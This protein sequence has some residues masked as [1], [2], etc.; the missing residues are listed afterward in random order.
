[1]KHFKIAFALALGAYP[2]YPTMAGVQ[3]TIL[4]KEC[5]RDRCVFYEGSRRRFSV[6]REQG[7]SRLVVRDRRGTL[8]AKV[9]E[10]E[11]D[12]YLRIEGTR[13]RR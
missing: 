2:V 10:E 1:M 13:K 12:G 7:T 9:R 4:R 3:D 8:R 5:T 11:E 6:E